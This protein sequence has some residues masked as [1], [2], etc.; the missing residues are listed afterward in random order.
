MITV[1]TTCTV[2]IATLE[3]LTPGSDSS[4]DKEGLVGSTGEDENYRSVETY[5]FH[6]HPHKRCKEE[7]VSQ[8]CHR[9]QQ[10]QSVVS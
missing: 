3:T 10:V 5:R 6:T 9:L 7:I 1:Q 2:T 8:R 4:Y